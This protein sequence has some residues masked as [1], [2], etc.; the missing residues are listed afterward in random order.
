MLSKLFGFGRK[1]ESKPSTGHDSVANSFAFLGTDMH[2]HL[3]P[4]IDDGAQIIE[5]SITL[6]RSLMAMGYSNFITTPHI[7]SDIY[8]NNTAIIQN[9]LKELQQAL[10]EQNIHVP[11]HAAAEYYVDDRFL[12]ML[13]NNE[14]L[15]TVHKKEVLIEFSFM[16]EPVRLN[17]TIFKIQ[18]KGYTPIFA[19]PERYAFFHH[20][21]EIFKDIKDRGCLLQ[22]NTLS[23]SGYYGKSIMEMA[24]RL[25]N[26]GL[27]DYCGTDLHH[28]NH[29]ESLLK[30]SKS[31]SYSTIQQYPFINKKLAH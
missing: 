18:T 16:F 14:P 28:K 8:P 6:I 30:F 15:L 25:I 31:K 20:K 9:A 19:H 11:I 2:S 29:V 4:G 26:D 23:L 5:D 27:Y 3:L 21:P 13:E 10:K 24:A 12:D 22:L 1:N 7:K 17:D